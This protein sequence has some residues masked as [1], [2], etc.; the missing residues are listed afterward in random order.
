MNG[1][2][3]LA[4]SAP[5]VRR[6]LRAEVARRR[7]GLHVGGP[8]DVR[9]LELV[10]DVG[11]VV[12]V[13]LGPAVVVVDPP[14]VAAGGGDVVRLAGVGDAEVVGRLPVGRGQRRD[15]RRVRVADHVVGLVVFQHDDE[16]VVQAGDRRAGTPASLAG[17]GTVCLAARHRQRARGQRERGR[18][19]HPGSRPGQVS[20]GLRHVHGDLLVWYVALSRKVRN[21]QARRLPTR[22][23]QR[24]TN[25]GPTAPTPDECPR[26]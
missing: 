3:L 7:H 15:V 26:D 16:H 5:P 10:D 4:Y 6:P 19:R 17:G 2:C 12:L 18:G 13:A 21:S 1:L 14:G 25:S 8:R 9:R 20:P 11:V 22:E 23:G 24:P